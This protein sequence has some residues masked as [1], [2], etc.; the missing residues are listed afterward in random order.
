M[1]RNAPILLLD[2]WAA[3]QDPEFRAYFYET[4]LPQLRAEGRLVVV[5]AEYALETGQVD[6]F[7]VPPAQL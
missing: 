4:L 7:D 1:L 3:D 2:E 6:F 5:G